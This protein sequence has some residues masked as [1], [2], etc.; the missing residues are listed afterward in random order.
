MEL[1]WLALV[2]VVLS[3]GAGLCDGCLEEE[4]SALFQLK[5]FFE[6]INYKFQPNNFELNP[7]KESSSNCCEWERVECNPITGRVT[8]LFLNYSGYNKM[9]WYLNASL[10]LPFEELQSLSLIGNSIAGCV[11]NQGFERLS[12]KL[13]KLENLDLSVNYFNDSILASLS[14]LSSLKSLNLA[15]NI[16]TG[17]NPTN[18]IEMLPKLNNLETLDLSRNHLGNNILSQL[19]GF[20]S[21]KSLGLKHCGLKGT[22]NIQESNNNWMNLKEL[23]LG[24]NEINSLGSLFHGKEGMKLNKLE[25]L[26]LYD[27]LFNNS[28]FPSLAVLSNLK[29]LDLSYNQLEGAIYTKDLNALSNLEDLILSGNEV[30]G[31][32]PSQGIRLMNLKV[33]DLSRNDFNNSIMSSLATLSN[34]KTLWIDIYQCNGLIDMKDF[35]GFSNLEELNMACNLD[36]DAGCSF[37]LQSLGLFPTLKTLSLQGFNINETT[38]PSYSHNEFTSLKRLELSYCKVNK[39]FTRQEGLNLRSLEELELHESSLPSNFIQVFGPLISLK[40]LTAHGIDG[41]NTPPMNDFCELINLQELDING[42]NLRGSLPMC[43]SNLTSL[44]KLSLSYNQL[45]E[46]I[47]VLKNLT[48]LESLDLSSN[49]FSGNIFALKSLTLLESLDLSSNQFSES[50]SALK[51]LTLLESLDLSSNQFSESI[52]ALKSLTLLESL[53]LS[54][55]QFSGN[56]SALKS[57][58]LLESLDLSSNQFSGNISALKSLTLLES[59]DLSSNQFSG[60]ISALQSL[61]LLESLDL[62]SNQF[63]G[64]ISALESLTS[65]QLLDISNNKF[66]IPSSLRPL[67]NL[68]KLK[69]LNADNNNIH[70][71]DH[72]MSH[73]SAPRFQLST[74]KLSCCGSGGSFPQFLY[75]QSELWVVFLSDIYFKVDRFPFWLLENNTKLVTLSLMNCSLS[76]PFQVPSYVHSALSYLDISNNAFGGNIPVKMGAHLPVLGYL[77]MSKNYFNGSIPSSFGDMSSLEVLDLSNNQLSREIPEHMTMGCSLLQVLALSNNKLQGSIFSGNFNLTNFSTLELNGNNFTG[78]IPNV[79]AN[80]SY[81]YILDLSNNSIFGEVPSWIWN[82][83]ELAALDVSRNQLFGRLPQWRGYASNL[84]QVA[85]ADNQLEGSIPRAICSLNFKLQFLDLSMNSLSG[86]LP[87]CF[88][89]VSV[90]EVHL[91]KNKLQGALPNAFHDSSS[92]VT[93][94]LSYNHL[95]GNIPN[96]VSNLSK[97]SYLLLRRNH[98]EGEIPI[99]LCKL[100]R[101]SLIDLSQ[102]NL[103]GGIP[104]CLKVFALNYAPEQYIWHQTIYYGMNSSVSIEVSIEYT[105]KSRSYNYKRRMLQYM[106]GIDLSCNKLTGEIS[107]ETKNIKKIFT[108]NLSHNSLTGPV[109]QAFSNLMDMESLDLSYNNLTGNIPAEF[110]VLHFLEYFNV[111][112]NNLSG[113]TP[114]RIGQLG[115]FDESNYVGNPFLCGSLVGKNCSPVETPLTPKASA[116]NKEDHGFIDMDAFY[117]SFFACYVMVLLCIAAVLYINPYWRQ[118]W[119]YHIHMA[120]DSC[121]YFVIDNFPRSF[122]SGNM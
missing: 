91:F 38:M 87:S 88:K 54:S 42:N 35:Y 93:L 40:N 46:N 74:I 100:D 61:T 81:L 110:A 101:L 55:N 66:H 20:T 75:H 39:N 76:G 89:P 10:F 57:L 25:V 113:K 13:D 3:L 15:Y 24:G 6:F 117:A 56:I 73:S 16:F 32:I 19:D 92:L 41:N 37:S 80:C 2:L 108:L 62:S 36:A 26:S 11:V 106:S 21:L 17:S 22:L 12:L 65:L 121:Y 115:A 103:S 109:P 96:W 45:F 84:E 48:L 59:L 85:M 107:F 69:D 122:F 18:G 78:M 95:K 102:N 44:K 34:L 60:N 52:S 94:D 7:K 14:E 67:F 31:F 118:A 28:I 43:F 114:E 112:H 58:T 82:M 4:R 27:N 77:N 29:S 1:K 47:S 119:F 53:D 70:A 104:S 23:Y 111:S 72:E 97:L 120:V 99:Q 9:D 64:N 71:D 79:L 83:S 33:V 86:T 51:S 98:F 50:I 30:N 5:P 63:S 49:Q 90:R 105:V 8:H 68:S 116:G